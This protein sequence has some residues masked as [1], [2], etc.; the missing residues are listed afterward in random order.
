MF[1]EMAAEWHQIL[2]LPGPRAARRRAERALAAAPREAAGAGARAPVLRVPPA[3]GDHG[4]AFG[5]PVRGDQ[6]AL[7]LPK[8]LIFN[9]IHATNR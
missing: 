7:R 4:A 6:P 3:P 2:G 8:M 5:V 9:A 1:L